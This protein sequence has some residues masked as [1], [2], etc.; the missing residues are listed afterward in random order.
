[1]AVDAHDACISHNGD[2]DGFSGM[3]LQTAFI[4]IDFSAVTRCRFD[5]SPAP[6]GWHPEQRL[7]MRE[8][9]QGYTIGAAYAAGLENQLG[10]L[11]PGYYADLIVLEKDPFTCPVEELITLQSACRCWSVIAERY[12][13]TERSV[14]L[15]FSSAIS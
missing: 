8:A 2:S 10:R 9:L 13:S 3:A 15:V 11:S 6:K 4:G 1:M 12:S 5:G 7:T 14:C